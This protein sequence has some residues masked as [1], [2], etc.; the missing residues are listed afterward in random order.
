MVPNIVDLVIMIWM[1]GF[2]YLYFTFKSED[3]CPVKY[4]VCTK[5]RRLVYFCECWINQA[6]YDVGYENMVCV[7]LGVF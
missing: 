3:S 4:A 5:R 7:L 1:Q 6:L 2:I